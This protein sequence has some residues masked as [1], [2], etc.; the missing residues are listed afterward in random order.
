VSLRSPLGRVLGLGSAKD[1][2]SHWWSARLSALALVPL[3]IWFVV[4]LYTVGVRD[5]WAVV[6]FVQQPVNA[7]LLMLLVGAAAWHSLLGTQEIVEDYVH[8]HGAKIAAMIL[9]QFIHVVFGVAALYA[10]IKVSLGSA[11]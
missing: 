6:R 4:S 3:S 7:V 1:G 11:L 10:V 9:L 2:T 5:Y 8:E